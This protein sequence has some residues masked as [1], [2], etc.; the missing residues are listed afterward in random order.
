MNKLMKPGL[1]G[2]D[3]LIKA[4]ELY[5]KVLTEHPKFALSGQAQFGPVRCY[6][7]KGDI[8]AA[9]REAEKTIQQYPGSFAAQGAQKLLGEIEAL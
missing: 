3:Y 2:Y 4:I 5:Q 9:R 7:L 1:A 6:F 8:E